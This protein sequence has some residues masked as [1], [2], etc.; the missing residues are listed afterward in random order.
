MII[1]KHSVL[2]EIGSA[3]N[4]WSHPLQDGQIQVTGLSPGK[5]ILRICAISNEEK[6]KVYEEKSIEVVVARPPWASA[7]AIADMHFLPYQPLQ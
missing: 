2:M 5:Y 6:Y 7:W 3:Y 1:L 4:G